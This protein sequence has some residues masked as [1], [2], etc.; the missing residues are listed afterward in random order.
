VSGYP[1]PIVPV[2]HIEPVPRRIR[3]VVGSATVV[4]TLRAVYRWDWPYYPQYYLPVDDVD[5]GFLDAARPDDVTLHDGLGPDAAAAFAHIRWGSVDAWY[6]E[7]ERV[8][9]H[10]R[11]PYSRVDAIRSTREV[12][13]E[14]DGVELARSSSPVM[15]FETG[16]PTRY[17]LNPTD[18]RWQHLVESDTVTECPYKGTTSGYWS[19]RV[20]ETTYDDLAWSYQFPTRQL[21]PIAGMVAFYNEKLDITVAG[22]RLGRPDTHFS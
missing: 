1:K 22:E 17:Y 7:D 14:L 2:G 12:V 15:V 4:D 16:L 3:A 21:L 20:R 19:V 9:V 6:E 5:A 10:P 18:V 11:S 8:F 13:V